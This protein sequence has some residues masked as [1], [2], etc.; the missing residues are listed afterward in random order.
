MSPELHNA[1]AQMAQETFLKDPLLTV[2]HD[3]AFKTKQKE[4]FFPE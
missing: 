2:G 4:V 3:M 1:N